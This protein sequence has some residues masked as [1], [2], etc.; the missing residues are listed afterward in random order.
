[1]S[2]V[3]HIRACSVFDPARYVP[4]NVDGVR[5]GLVRP[6]FAESL[7]PFPEV[8]AVSAGSVALSPRLSDF[9]RR[10]AAVDGALREIAG[11]GLISGWRNEPFPV[12][13][14]PA[15]PILLNMERAAVPLFGIRAYGVHLNGFVRD[16]DALK[17][18]IGRRSL[19]RPRS[20]GKLDQLVAG[21]QPA[22]LS[23]RENL[24]KECGEEASIP[25]ALAARAVAVGAVSYVTETEEGLRRDV[26]YDYDLE[27]PPGFDPRNTDGEIDE[28]HLW[29]IDRVLDTVRD[30]HDFKFNCS[31]VVIDFLIRHGLIEPDHPDYLTLVHGLRSGMEAAP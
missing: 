30:T 14:S 18:W 19:R 11:Q 4:F 26:L 25:L 16:G 27:L 21:G 10:T 29:P 1:V 15:G 17:M 31:L 2:F 3:D 6:E 22:G 9:D 20:P 28:F 13:A 5:V 12:A 7:K 23:L 24:I 8:F